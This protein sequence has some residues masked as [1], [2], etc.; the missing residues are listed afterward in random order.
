MDLFP[1]VAYASVPPI[2][3]AAA[4]PNHRLTTEMQ[5]GMSVGCLHVEVTTDKYSYSAH[6]EGDTY[7]AIT[8]NEDPHSVLCRRR[9]LEANDAPFSDLTQRSR[10]APYAKEGS[11]PS[12]LKNEMFKNSCQENFFDDK[13]GYS[14]DSE[15][16]EYSNMDSILSE[17]D[18]LGPHPPTGLVRRVTFQGS[19]ALDQ[20]FPIQFYYSSWW[21]TNTR[22]ALPLSLDCHLLTSVSGWRLNDELARQLRPVLSQVYFQPSVRHLRQPAF[23]ALKEEELVWWRKATQG[24]QKM[25]QAYAKVEVGL[26]SSSLRFLNLFNCPFAAGDAELE[27]LHALEEICLSRM[28]VVTLDF[29]RK[30]HNLKKIF[31]SDLHALQ[32][33]V[34]RAV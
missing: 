20:A 1:Y 17:Q 25:F 29:L 14:Y 34:H 13:R 5:T 2:A 3:L 22:D 7:V 18:P 27:C 8:Q 26:L 10:Y 9:P 15:D 32:S 33:L 19:D 24:T 4:S 11:L 30:N 23:R 12:D 21:L 31:V 28:A 6:V 16:A